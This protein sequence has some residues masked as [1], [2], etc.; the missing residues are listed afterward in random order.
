M[1]QVRRTWSLRHRLLPSGMNF[2]I[3]SS[4]VS[5]AIG[6]SAA[7]NYAA[8]EL[9]NWVQAKLNT[10][11]SV[12]N[13]LGNKSFG[14]IAALVAVKSSIIASILRKQEDH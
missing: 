10:D 11:V 14:D 2:F 4:P 13:T 1:V 12:F 9:R 7:A 6:A 8:V 5:G 3:T